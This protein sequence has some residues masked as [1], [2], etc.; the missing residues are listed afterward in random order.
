[1]L[2]AYN[3]Q[4][5][6]PMADT[7]KPSE[8][9]P[10]VTLVPRPSGR[11]PRLSLRTVLGAAVGS[12]AAL[13]FAVGAYSFFGDMVDPRA[14]PPRPVQT[15]SSWPEM[16]DGV[17]PIATDPSAEIRSARLDPA[18]PPAKL[19]LPA[20]PPIEARAEP[21]PAPVAVAPPPP[22]PAPAPVVAA[23][24]PPAETTPPA[25]RAQPPLQDVALI[26]PPPA[27]AALGPTKAETLKAKK[28]PARY[29]AL[30]AADEPAK[31]EKPDAPPPAAE[32]PAAKTGT[33]KP[34]A[35]K[36]PAAKSASR[37]AQTAKAAP[38]PEAPVAEAAPPRHA[39]EEP[40]TDLPGVRQIRDGFKAVFGGRGEAEQNAQAQ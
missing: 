37:K 3:V 23:A 22:P 20:P 39:T 29:A 34:T 7:Q 19:D 4:E 30:P 18:P 32:G 2:P 36:P 26:G 24:P 38:E 31:T 13:G 11:L 28:L 14:R 1:M 25:K 6:I 9:R 17:P 27:M 33:V 15:A 35:A 5:C 16:R 8:A 10:E 21:V 40:D 12:A